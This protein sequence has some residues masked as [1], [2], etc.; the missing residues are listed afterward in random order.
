[1]REFSD[2]EGKKW[3]IA[4]TIG[5]AKRVKD[6][7]GVDLLDLHN[8]EPPMITRLGTEIILV[9]DVVCACVRPQLAAADMSDEDFAARLG[10]AA[11]KAAVDAFFEELADFTLSIGLLAD[12]RALARLR[13]ALAREAKT[14]A[15]LVDRIDMNGII[16]KGKA[17]AEK[18]LK[19]HGLLSTEAPESSE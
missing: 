17:E 2:S 14:K 15:A 11:A 19:D 16:A 1:M 4:L 6:L 8:G 5:V 9:I 12:A 13:E 18:E 3:T 7:I 10:G